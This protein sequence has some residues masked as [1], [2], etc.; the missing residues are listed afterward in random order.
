MSG[1]HPLAEGDP[2]Q[3]GDYR[4]TGVLGEG[5]QGVVYLGQ[6][7]SGQPVA[8]KALHA[9]MTADPAARERFL[10]EAEIT[11]R[12][13]AFCT[14]RVIDAGIARDR[15][16]LVSEYVRGP[17][18]DELITHDGP[19]TGG[20]LDRLAITTLT[21]L[22][23]I[24]RAGIVHRDFKPSN[25]I[26]GQEGPVVIDFGIA[27]VLGHS[28]TRSGLMG[29]PAYLSP[30]Q[31]NGHRAGTASDVFAWAATMVYAATGHPAFPGVI[32]A[33]VISAI[34]TREPDLAGVP[35]QLRPLL[36]ACLAKDPAARPGVADLFTALTHGAPVMGD[37][38]GKHPGLPFE[39]PHDHDQVSQV[40]ALPGTSEPRTVA[41]HLSTPVST[42]GTPAISPQAPP[43]PSGSSPQAPPPLSGSSPV[44]A[45]PSSSSSPVATSLPADSSPRRTRRRLG[46]TL[47]A[48]VVVI[49]VPAAFWLKPV[50]T[51]IFSGTV[52]PTAGTGSDEQP[53]PSVTG[54]PFGTL[55][56][57]RLA[58]PQKWILS[59]AVGQLGSRPVVVSGGYDG[60]VLVSDLATGIP[61]GSPF[62]GHRGPVW[63][64]AVGQ[65]DGRPAV[66]SGGSDGTVLV[67]DLATGAPLGSPFKGHRGSVES[68][69]VGQ[70]DGRPVAVSG[71]ND[72]TV[73]VSDLATG[74]PIG[75]PFTGH[76]HWVLAV[77]VGQLDGRPVVVS[78]GY[79]RT[80][81]VSDLA[82]GA[83][84]G[85]SFTGHRGPIESIA[86]GQLDGRPVAVSGGGKGDHT[87]RIWDLATGTPVGK[88]LT[89]HRSWA[90]GLAVGQLGGRPTVV[91]GGYNDRTVRIWDMAT[92]APLGEPFKGHRGLIESVAVGQLDGRPVAV[93]G[94]ND[95]TVRVWGLGPPYPPPGL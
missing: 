63:S 36:T 61:V 88:P 86:T 56:G 65:L 91:S 95:G 64:V 57:G 94:G 84:I 55:V 27:R 69:A 26:M 38:G 5:G 17:S 42:A 33:A 24:H 77:A 78:G 68:V 43:P 14:A 7:P 52:R 80:V 82:T 87:V 11:R 18:L 9:R 4:L 47:T 12:V 20:G 67:S 34:V 22:A 71:G 37:S 41:P 92:G 30:E 3:L 72:G 23:A 32:P 54:I 40:G 39:L 8:V 53:E 51:D 59:L 62:T 6:A 89:G 81:L 75:K 48:A 74:T 1:P 31:L 13:A 29:T 73:L 58:G 83:P 85:T 70:L 21:A 60:T 45:P 46:R 2:R 28:T 16:Y 93:S 76:R 35:D 10:R 15:P 79:N 19:R 66:V 90:L 44:A 25:V 49:L 50:L